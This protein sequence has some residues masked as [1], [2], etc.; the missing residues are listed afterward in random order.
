MVHDGGLGEKKVI[1]IKNSLKIIREEFGNFS[2]EQSSSWDDAFL[3][4]F[5]SK[6]PEVGPK[7]A[8]CIMSYTF[9]RAAFGVDAHVGRVLARLGVCQSLDL[10]L[11]NFDHKLK[12]K[13][14]QNLIPPT[15]RYSLHVNLLEHGRKMCKPK[16]P[17]C[18][19][20]PLN[21]VC[22]KRII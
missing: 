13:I 8:L 9:E 21:S 3:Q 4:N 18:K 2:M 16:S 10:D 20:C 5:L 14:L 11:N 15:L 19:E 1:A 7:S 22:Q 12:Q 6:M 17:S